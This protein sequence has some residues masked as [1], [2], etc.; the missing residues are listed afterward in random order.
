MFPH[1]TPC[2]LRGF[3]ELHC[4]LHP[5]KTSKSSSSQSV[6]RLRS[7]PP[8]V[9]LLLQTSWN[10]ESLRWSSSRRRCCGLLGSGAEGAGH[11]ENFRFTKLL[12][13]LPDL[14]P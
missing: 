6:G 11:Q 9:S 1:P 8:A 7:L 10:G 14:G 2:H 12:L 5:C 4:A 13:K 3:W